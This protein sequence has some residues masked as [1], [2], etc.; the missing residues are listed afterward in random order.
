MIAMPKAS[1]P[2]HRAGSAPSAESTCTAPEP[3][4]DRK[5]VLSAPSRGTGLLWGILLLV[6]IRAAIQSADHE[7]VPADTSRIVHTLDPNVAPWWEL[8]AIPR[9]GPATALAIEYERRRA[10]LNSETAPGGAVFRSAADLDRVRG[11]GPVTAQMISPYL[12][13]PAAPET[14][15]ETKPEP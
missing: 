6:F 14:A 7:P 2:L 9:I 4:H 8:S 12:R 1:S 11:I 13:F 10:A 5:R 15:R 3:S